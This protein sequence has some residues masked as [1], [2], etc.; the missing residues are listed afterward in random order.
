M[1][2]VRQLIGTFINVLGSALLGPDSFGRIIQ[3]LGDSGG[4]VTQ[5]RRDENNVYFGGTDSDDLAAG[6]D[7]INGH[8]IRCNGSSHFQ[9]EA[10]FDIDYDDIAVEVTVDFTSASGNDTIWM[11]GPYNTSNQGMRLVFSSTQITF[12]GGNG[13]SY[14]VSWA[15]EGPGVYNVLCRTNGTGAE[16]YVN[17]VLV[18]YS[19]GVG[20]PTGDKTAYLGSAG[21][22][23]YTNNSLLCNWRITNYARTT[24]IHD[25]T[26]DNV[27]VTPVSQN[28]TPTYIF[29]RSGNRN[30][31]MANN[32]YFGLIEATSLSRNRDSFYKHSHC[33][34][35]GRRNAL[36][37]GKSAHWDHG[38][39]PD[40]VGIHAVGPRSD[41]SDTWFGFSTAARSGNLM[42]SAVEV[43]VHCN[44][45][46]E[47]FWIIDGVEE[48]TKFLD[49]SI[50]GHLEIR[51][52]G[53]DA[54]FFVDGVSRGTKAMGTTKVFDSMCIYN[55]NTN[56][57]WT[58]GWYSTDEG[59]TKTYYTSGHVTPY[60]YGERG[61]RNS[62]PFIN[63]TDDYFNSNVAT[64]ADSARSLYSVRMEDMPCVTLNDSER[65]IWNNQDSFLATDG[66]DPVTW[67]GYIYRTANQSDVIWSKAPSTG[68][69]S[70]WAIW[71]ISGQLLLNLINN[72]G[73][74][75]YIQV[76][77]TNADLTL[78]A[79]TYFEIYYAGDK[80]ATNITMKT[81][82]NPDN[83]TSRAITINTDALTGNLETAH[84][85]ALGARYNVGTDLYQ[86]RM[87]G[88]EMTIDGSTTY[89]PCTEG[90]GGIVG[91]C[92]DQNAVGYLTAGTIATLWA[93]TQSVF[94]FKQA[95]GFTPLQYYDGSTGHV[96]QIA[97]QDFDN[98]K[99]KFK[100]MSHSYLSSS[101]PVGSVNAGSGDKEFNFRV[102]GTT[103]FA[104]FY[105]NVSCTSTVTPV[106]GKVH[107]VVLTWNNS[108][109]VATI[110]VDNET[111]VSSSTGNGNQT[112]NPLGIGARLANAGLDL[113]Y[114][115]FILDLQ[116]TDSSDNVIADFGKQDVD[117]RRY[118]RRTT[119]GAIDTSPQFPDTT[120]ANVV[121]CIECEHV[122]VQDG[123]MACQDDVSSNR[124]WTRD[125]NVGTSR[126]YF[127]NAGGTAYFSTVSN[128][129]FTETWGVDGSTCFHRPD[130]GTETTW[131]LSTSLKRSSYPI[132]LMGRIATN[133]QNGAR[134]G[135]FMMFDLD[136]TTKTRAEINTWFHNNRQG[137]DR[138]N[139]SSADIDTYGIVFAGFCDGNDTRLGIEGSSYGDWYVNNDSTLPDQSQGRKSGQID[140]E[141]TYH[142]YKAGGT[143]KVAEFPAVGGT[144]CFGSTPRMT[145]GDY[146][147]R[148]DLTEFDM[149]GGTS[150][151]GPL[152]SPFGMRDSTGGNAMINGRKPLIDK[153]EE[154]QDTIVRWRY[155]KPISQANYD[156]LST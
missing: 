60:D 61:G 93:N 22:N 63:G 48:G 76:R 23:E 81:G 110:S 87:C 17:N 113:W 131:S 100:V 152:N 72:W 56:A 154:T 44:S 138:W 35:V 36:A 133:V 18:N 129:T 125:R 2:G 33:S 119:S 128:G 14:S 24:I 85:V 27:Q 142:A 102:D 64:P 15:H 12:Q 50:R 21:G 98:H 96:T 5:P 120:P 150:D 121:Y 31:L 39:S 95:N 137:R 122:S 114:R 145:A 140:L 79:W 103:S 66:N 146:M 30:G 123:V 46:N 147:L 6:G 92:G 132:E 37:T 40:A 34:E 115:G 53:T 26:F 106:L 8:G 104:F 13:L 101:C 32:Q 86:G 71:H 127:W 148:S 141:G 43:G 83:L 29:D 143:A 134:L 55:G 108:T 94:D 118:M 77:T 136:Q 19:T 20:T 4:T 41:M 3:W 130:V 54:E 7:P 153:T 58:G 51:H 70:G 67:R 68:T 80:D 9:S 52:D 151:C 97:P 107:D 124:I 82:P 74:G 59:A 84:D 1:R 139:T 69:L 90:N 111:P 75:N 42:T 105:Q 88:L 73:G 155:E 135:T 117:Q 16:L 112:S 126:M 62:I 10:Q 149:G 109:N 116:L 49:L 91:A 28:D 11:I 65:V 38:G 57:I 156:D 89:I 45:S 99:L 144:D 25:Y 47:W 78:N